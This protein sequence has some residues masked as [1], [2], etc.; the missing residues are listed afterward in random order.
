MADCKYCSKPAGIFHSAH[1]ECEAA[2]ASG[3]ARITSAIDQALAADGSTDSLPVLI[4]QTAAQSFIAPSERHTMLVAGWTRTLDGFLGHG[5]LG[6]SEQARL[7][8]FMD[9]FALSRDELNESQAFDR[10]VKAITLREVMHGE[11]PQRCNFVGPL[12]VNLEKGE[13]VVWI[14]PRTEYLEDR[15]HRQ[16][17]GGSA[18]VSVRVVKGVYF[19]TSSFKG[20]PVDRTVRQLVDTGLFVATNKNIYFAGPAKSLR[21]PYAKIV[22]FQPYSDGIGVVRD[23]ASAKPQVFVTHDGWFTYNLVTNLAKL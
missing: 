19:H 4:D 22:S 15:T 5:V 3:V 7:G 18:G 17:V 1:K 16:Y 21:L 9:K 14:F 12:P 13:Q 10:M 11:I 23:S 6:E 8:H 20:Q 2:H